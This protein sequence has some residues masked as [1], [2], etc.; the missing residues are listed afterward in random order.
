VNNAP[1]QRTGRVAVAL[2]VAGPFDLALSLK[3][4]ASFLPAIGPAPTALRVGVRL[5][6]R[7]AVIE[8]RQNGRQLEA[9]GPASISPMSLREI[10]AR[11]VNVD[12]DLRSFYGLSMS[13]PVI[14]PIT[15]S[16]Y[17][18]K[19][20]RPACL[21]EMLVIA[22][23][24]QQLSLAAA[25]YIRQRLVKRFGN[26]LEGIWLFPTPASL[27]KAPL[28]GLKA[29]GLSGRK[30]EYIAAL[31]GEIVSGRLDLAALKAMSDAEVRDVLAHQRGLGDW[32]IDYVLAR[33]LGRLDCL[34]AADVGLRRVVGQYL[35]GGSR[36]SAE[37]LQRFLAPFVPFRTLAAYYLA[38]HARLFLQRRF[39]SGP[40]EETTV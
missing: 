29:C 6:G 24:E 5:A 14:G 13:H 21:F 31:A 17:G 26:R 19:P 22:I 1:A 2:T 8:M 4:A 33:G 15:R 9:V 40:I 3:G 30:S 7:P 39:V 34:P 27:A 25:F 37:E 36:L 23:T 16:L 28:S 35:A 18:L 20:L 12:L 38:V 11:L 32:S 10:A